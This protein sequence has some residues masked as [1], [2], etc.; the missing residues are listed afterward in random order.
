MTQQSTRALALARRKALSGAG[1]KA[2]TIAASE[3]TRSQSMQRK[4][5]PV[6]QAAIRAQA[7]NPVAAPAPVSAPAPRRA[8]SAPA[9][10]NTSRA[11]AL[12]RRKAMSTSGKKA[13]SSTDRTSAGRNQPAASTA[14]AVAPTEA[15]SGDCGCGCNGAGD[16]NDT[17]TSAPTL[18][19]RRNGS[20]KV[21]AGKGGRAMAITNPSKAA[22]MARRQAQSSR[23]KAGLSAGGMTA[24]Q[25]ARAGNPDLTSRELARALREQRSQRGGAGLKKSAP[26][27]RTRPARNNGQVPAQGAATDAPWKVGI[28]ET[29]R[30][31]AVTG[32]MVGRK[33]GMTGDE[34]STC[35]TVTGTE[36]MGADV[37]RD[38]CHAE[39][40]KSF[41]DLGLG[42]T[43]RGNTVTGNKVGRSQKVTGDEPGSCKNVTGTEYLS[44]GQMAACGI[45]AG[46]GPAKSTSAQTIASTR[47]GKSV[48]G[49]NV[50]RSGKVTGDETGADRQLTGTQYMQRDTTKD[51]A[52]A[53]AKVGASATLR[54]GAVTGTMVGRHKNMTGDEAG[55]CRNVTGDDYIGQEQFGSFCESMPKPK[56]QKVGVSATLS[57]ER[58]T[59]TMTGRGGKVTGDEP[60][61]CKAI[62]G[63]P[64]AGAEQYGAFCEPDQAK[65][66][67]A[68]MQ[69]G[70]R[71]F[72]SVMTGI[73][74]AVGGRMTGDAKGACQAVSGTPYVGADQ[75]VEACASLPPE[76]SAPDFPQPLDGQGWGQFSVAAPAHA[77]DA[78]RRVSNVTGAMSDG[79]KITGPFGMAGGKVTG[80][81]DMRFGRNKA[82]PVELAAPTAAPLIDGRVKSRVTGEGQSSGLRVTGDDWDRGDRVTGTE[83]TSAQVRNPSRRGP[84]QPMAS[85][86]A[87]GRPEST[88]QPVSKITGASGNYEGGSLI[89]FSG[90]ARG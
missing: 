85:A 49:N 48:T 35:R 70:K 14:S 51:R 31:Q 58:I 40:A 88:P 89:T 69:P 9:A 28:S 66:A 63:T 50:G 27:G 42:K 21:R 60:G 55:S 10:T 29:S 59:G 1:K 43:G 45:D 84:Q 23:G 68:R 6:D 54:G 64:Y 86:M 61:T 73:Q 56:D 30:G 52:T 3:R 81:D 37:F 24:A 62:T 80:T 11:K 65:A 2:D 75:V 5:K 22:S 16:C 90:G 76:M 79:G 13:D 72:G 32:T 4:A 34:A 67:A 71:M 18:G 20:A 26:T 15:K 74:P 41:S 8:T 12:A 39:P 38:F 78:P 47:G 57:G 82:N 83:G 46:K 36:Y 87:Q 7:G 77:A 44:A 17:K 53:P 19:S 25:T 33:S